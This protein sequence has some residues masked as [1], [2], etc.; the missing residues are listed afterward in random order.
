MS[1]RLARKE[2]ISLAAL[3]VGDREAIAQMVEEYSPSIYRMAL[4]M[5]GNEQD[6]E[7]ILQESFMKAIRALCNFEERSSLSTWLYRIAMNEI[8]MLLGK[9]KQGFFSVDE[10][11]DSEDGLQEP[12][13]IVDWC[14]MPERELMNSEAR[15]H[16]NEAVQELSPALRSVFVLR[17]IEGL[18]V[19]ETADALD[20]SDAAVK[21]RLLR[22]RLHLRE[23]L[24]G[25]YGR[26]FN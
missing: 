26:R 8:L 15:N 19:R 7:D 14:C 21:T 24:S 23:N 10:E 12:V 11:K 1:D 16:L 5:L 18:S 20:I 22:A 3:K 2:S 13:E 9:Q 25:Y 6:A 17:D 4:R